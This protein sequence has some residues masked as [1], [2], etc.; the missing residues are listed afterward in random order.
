VPYSG[1]LGLRRHYVQ[2][3]WTQSEIRGRWTA[4]LRG[5]V[6]V[7]DGGVALTPGLAYAPRGDLTLNLDAVLLLGPADAEYRLAPIRAAV[8]ARAKVL[9]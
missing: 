5:V 1:G 9:F 4:A 7:S 2:A 6:G 8:Q 3:A